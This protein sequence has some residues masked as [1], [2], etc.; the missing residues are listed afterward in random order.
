MP[1]GRRRLIETRLLVTLLGLVV[2]AAFLAIALHRLDWR[3][4]SRVLGR[5]RLWP[6][7][8]A[9]V[10][11]YLAGHLVRGV[12]CKWLLSRQAHLSLATAA[13]VVVVGYAVNNLLPA[14]AGEL[15]R[16]AMVSE[17]TGIPFP[18]S[19]TIIFIERILDGLAILVLF[20]AGAWLTAFHA[21][22]LEVPLWVATAVFATAALVIA[23]AVTGPRIVITITSRL[24]ARLPSRWQHRAVALA[25]SFAAGAGAMADARTAIRLFGLSLVIW[26]FEAGMFILLLP[27]LG[28][29]F[30]APRGVVAMAVTNLGLMVPSSPGFIGSFHL[31]CMKTVVALGADPTVGFAYAV[32]VH[33]T[34][35]LPVT[36]WGLAALFR[37]GVELASLE[38]VTGAIRNLPEAASESP[39]R[40][41]GIVAAT[42][43]T[44]PV[45]PGPLLR[46]I[47]DAVLPQAV[48]DLGAITAEKVQADVS[49]FVSGQI[50]ALPRR[51]QQALAA[52]LTAFAL[53]VR[54]R[55]PLGFA[56]QPR[57][58]RIALVDQWSFGRWAPGRK[59]F[60]VIRSTALLA[61][62]DHPAVERQ[63]TPPE[64]VHLHSLPRS[65]P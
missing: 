23:A 54:I 18:Q 58:R 7:L 53:S 21:G 30:E 11:S 51:L 41:V 17:R 27:A 5:A 19:L 2:S 50:Q 10:L 61:F 65:E 43:P 29:P 47:V 9:A 13:N 63:L 16:S 45:R 49:L 56:A 38:G 1:S 48:P 64:P 44:R 52:G 20:F 35:Y 8:P 39:L 37:Y 4:I 55:H 62:Y 22:W 32:L 60:R 59:L 26:T 28:L 6:W 57:A 34:F 25:G 3:A 31:F 15:A 46:A 12:R 33:A 42:A 36:V 14:R 24:S 40:V